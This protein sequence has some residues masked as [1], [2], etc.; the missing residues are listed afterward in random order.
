MRKNLLIGAGGHASKAL[1]IFQEQGNEISGFISTEPIGTEK[2]GLRVECTLESLIATAF[3]RR[4]FLGLH[5]AI[6]TPDVR[7]AIA[8]KLELQ[9]GLEQQL[10]FLTAQAAQSFVAASSQMGIGNYIGRFAVIEQYAK[11]GSHCIIDSHAIVEH[12]C[13]IGN[14]VNVSPNATLCGHVWVGDEVVIG[15]G[16]TVREKIKIGK[17]ALVAAGAVVVKDI[18]D[19]HVVAGCPA[20][21][22]SIRKPSD[23]IFQ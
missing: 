17:G 8:S 11:L 10:A 7:K 21:F 14:Y 3:N 19:Y 12:D 23:R 20:K 22:V 2:Y 15:A 4:K 9:D 6:G 5:I 1:A 18:P 16:A 13:L